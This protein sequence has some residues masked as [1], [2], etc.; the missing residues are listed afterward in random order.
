V[1]NKKYCKTK[2]EH[3]HPRASKFSDEHQL[4]TEYENMFICCMG[5]ESSR[6]VDK[7]N[8]NDENHYC[9]TAKDDLF[10]TL[11]P[12]ENN[13]INKLKYTNNGQ[14]YCIDYEDKKTLKTQ[15]NEI[16]K[17]KATSITYRKGDTGYFLEAGNLTDD[18]LNIAIQYDLEFTLNLNTTKLKNQRAA[19][20]KNIESEVS[21]KFKK[22]H[23]L[24]EQK[25]QFI[26]SKKQFFDALNFEGKYEPMCMVKIFYLNKRLKRLHS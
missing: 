24:S 20:W 11:D 8:N 26:D 5:G 21:Y 6:V 16:K 25:K 22:P 1:K 4:N 23:L 9:D 17:S 10:L 14:I 2:I 18:E 7:Y 13:H 19:K 3:W 12:R 15:Y